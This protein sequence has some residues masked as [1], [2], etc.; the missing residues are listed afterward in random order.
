PA[1]R[2]A[3]VALLGAPGGAGHVEAI[4]ALAQLA[5]PDA[6]HAIAAQ[7]TS[8]RPEVRAAAARALG[9]IRHEEAAARLEAL[10]SDYAARVRRA[11]I[12][13]L[14]KLP[15]GPPRPRR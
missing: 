13:A 3:L 15:G 14:S 12:E 7:L 11:A 5:G 1:G 9:R 6:G 4:E 10:R 2:D 8:D